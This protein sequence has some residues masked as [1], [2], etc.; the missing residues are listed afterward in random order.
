MPALM[1]KHNPGHAIGVTH[2]ACATHPTSTVPSVW[3]RP[4]TDIVLFESAIVASDQA[5]WDEIYA[6]YH[7]YLVK[8]IR[9]RYYASLSQDDDV[10]AELAH[11]AITR[12]ARCYTVTK[13]LNNA[14]GLGGILKYLA[15]CVVSE[16]IDFLDAQKVSAI[17]LQ[18]D[19]DDNDVQEH[20]NTGEIGDPVLDEVSR[21]DLRAR[22]WRCIEQSC[23]GD[24]RD[25]LIAHCKLR[26]GQKPAE[27]FACNRHL[28]RSKQE[29]FDRWHNLTDRLARSTTCAQ[30]AALV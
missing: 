24:H 18:A 11:A 28:F 15:T 4:S 13:W 21:R 27:I 22:L 25:L 23:R 9:A 14:A 29:I 16:V 3:H 5:A 19:P 1:E 7:P 10:V 30:L 17:E 8:L 6:I 26:L 20:L 12:F 2:Q